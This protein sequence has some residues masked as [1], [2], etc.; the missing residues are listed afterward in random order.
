[1]DFVPELANFME[2]CLIEWLAYI[3]DKRMKYIHLNYFT[4]DQLVILQR[5]LVKMGTE[6]NMSCRVYP[7]LSAIKSDC[8]PGLYLWSKSDNYLLLNIENKV[9]YELKLVTLSYTYIPVSCEKAVG[10]SPSQP[11]NAGYED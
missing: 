1:M 7:L 6:E 10:C 9:T 4:V 2:T 11:R 5:E 8:S 3:D